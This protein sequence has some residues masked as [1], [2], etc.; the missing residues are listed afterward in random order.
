MG[1]RLHVFIHISLCGESRLF[2]FRGAHF[3]LSF[4]AMQLSDV[5]DQKVT[6]NVRLFPFH[7]F[8]FSWQTSNATPADTFLSGQLSFFVLG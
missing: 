2:S 6:I 3:S 1:L 7:N 5:T 8:N 4:F